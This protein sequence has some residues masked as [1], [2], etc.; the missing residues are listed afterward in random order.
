MNVVVESGSTTRGKQIAP[1][2]RC[3]IYTRKS[4]EEGLDQDFN[5]LDAQR[6]AC[7]AYVTSQSSL[8]WRLSSKHYD[9][10]GISGGTM[11]R[12]AL[13]QL[14]EDVKAG[15]VD[16]IVVYKID[17]LTRSL[18]DFAKMVD[19]FDDKGI[20]FV[21]VTQQFNTTT[22]MGR[23]T[24]NVL[25]SFAQFE[26][27]VT[28]ERIRDKIAASKKKGMW[29]GGVVPLGY[30]VEDKKL[31][32]NKEEAKTVE[33][34]YLRYLELGSVTELSKE[35]LTN[36][37]VGRSLL[38]KNNTPRKTNPFG[39]G[40]LY[41][42]LSNPIY[43]GKVKHHDQ[44]YDGQHEAI[45]EVS[46]WD[47]VQ[48]KLKANA[49]N[50]LSTT[51]ATSPNL[52]TGLLHD[53]AGESLSPTHTNKKGKR[54]FYYVSKTSANHNVKD[55]LVKNKSTNEKTTWRLS[56]PYLDKTVLQILKSH[57]QS[58]LKLSKLINFDGMSVDNQTAII[59]AAK[60][61]VIKLTNSQITKQK[62]ILQSIIDRV[63]LTQTQIIIHI[64]AGAIFQSKPAKQNED[65]IQEPNI[66]TIQ[67]AHQL[68][69]RGVE[70]KLI[71]VSD[72]QSIR[73]PDKNL[74]MLIA[75]AN[76]WLTQLSD[77]SA[78]TITELA[79]QLNEDR[80]EISR[81]LPLAFLSPKITQAILHGAQPI[82]LTSER[83][84]RITNL[85]MD[86]DEQSRILGFTD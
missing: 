75:K 37:L 1:R 31:F 26:R 22:S 15:H 33:S 41:H 68:K 76:L 66:K 50:R 58:P 14:L 74:I 18:M 36:G 60:S 59:E 30:Q 28:A 79:K 55:V 35:A 25:L 46:I 20:S 65:Q 86:W 4:T 11:E 7:E 10:G 85:P 67:C 72:D 19:L 52:F 81:F 48:Q 56:A 57:L 51:N 3:A 2:L 42:L 40:N 8:G 27:E 61:L 45:I 77:G 69:K 17:R 54:Y 38:S 49:S 32:I 82:N 47:A 43:L 84:R 13:K 12:P 24:L 39:R 73:N 78:N 34:L 9:D 5:S 63:V 83:L 6:E 62:E 71:L 44:I 23:L 29:M 21:S 70:A 80:N 16:I 64:K 53:E